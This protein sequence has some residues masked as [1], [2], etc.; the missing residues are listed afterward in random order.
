MAKFIIEINSPQEQAE[1]LASYLNEAVQY[2][3]HGKLTELLITMRG[4][5]GKSHNK[6]VNK[7]LGLKKFL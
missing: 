2:T 6:M 7:A 4:T 1:K 5:D 3:D